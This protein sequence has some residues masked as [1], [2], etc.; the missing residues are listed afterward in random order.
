MENRFETFTLLIA[1]INRAIQKIK[2][3]EMAEFDLKSSHV[4]CLYYLYKE[5]MLTARDLCLI[6]G[7]DKANIS[8]SIKYLEQNGYLVCESTAQKRYLSAIKLTE[9]GR[10]V[11]EQLARRVDGILD[12]ASLGISE[13][14][15]AV[16]YRSLSLINENL[17]KICDEY[18]E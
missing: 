3:E 18:K 7:E 6:C 2:T 5:E 4:S 9:R 16:M 10:E 11:G 15:R 12:S 17:N 14:D 8:R 13:D 1:S